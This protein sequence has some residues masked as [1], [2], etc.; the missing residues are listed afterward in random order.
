[1]GGV[2]R[3]IGINI[4][5]PLDNNKRISKDPM[6]SRSNCP[7]EF[8]SSPF[9]SLISSKIEDFG[10]IFLFFLL[11]LPLYHLCATFEYFSKRKC[12]RI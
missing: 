7:F 8:L 11:S 5:T 2:H 10:K 6:I 9:K 4:K 3:A 12:I 1:M